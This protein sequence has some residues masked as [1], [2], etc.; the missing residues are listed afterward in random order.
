MRQEFFLTNLSDQ[1]LDTILNLSSEEKEEYILSLIETFYSKFKLTEQQVSELFLA[2]LSSFE[3]EKVYRTNVKFQC[4]FT[5]IYT[6]TGLIREV[7]NDLY[8]FK[9]VKTL[10]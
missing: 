5:L 6:N 7:T 8:R 2:Y 9:P 10:H 3:L 4:G 1:E